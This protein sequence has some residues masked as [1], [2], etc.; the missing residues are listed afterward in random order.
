MSVRCVKGTCCC[1]YCGGTFSID[2]TVERRPAHCKRCGYDWNLRSQDPKKCPNCGSTNWNADLGTYVCKQCEHTWTSRK[3][4]V[5]RKCPRC[6]SLLWNKEPV[7]KEEKGKIRSIPPETERMIV[8]CH[9]KGLE[10]FDAALTLDMP[11]FTVL[12]VY[13]K[14]GWF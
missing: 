13:H 4:G 11:V 1:P 12:S 14:R 9:D 8:G 10:L 5:P 2:N 6:Q 7:V 3:P